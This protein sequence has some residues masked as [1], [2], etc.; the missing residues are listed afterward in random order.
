VALGFPIVKKLTKSMI[1]ANFSRTLSILLESGI[2]ISKA[3]KISVKTVGNSLY[4]DVLSDVQQKLVAGNTLAQ[5]LKE[6]KKYFTDTFTKMIEVGEDT[7]TLEENLLYLHEFYAEE[8]DDMSKNLT[9]LLE[10]ILLV[11]IGLMVGMLAIAIVGPIY[12]LTG[13]I[14]K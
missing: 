1:L 14:G 5:S 9:T 4:A 11:F 10:P 12:Q 3:L 8:V 13:Q 6:H 2:P 7:G